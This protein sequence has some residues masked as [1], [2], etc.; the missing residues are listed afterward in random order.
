[1]EAIVYNSGHLFG[2]FSVFNADAIKNT[3]LIKGS[4]PANYGGRLS[5]V[6]DIQMKDGNNKNFG[7]QGGI[8]LISSRLTVEGPIQ[9]EKSSFIISGRRTYAFDLAQP[10]LNNTD[11]RGTNYYFYDLNTKVN[12]QLSPKDRLFFSAYFGKDVL[13]FSSVPRDFNFRMPWGNTTAT[14]RWNHL[15]SDRLFM[16]ASVIYND[17]EFEAQ[18]DQTD[19]TFRL[20]SG[21]RDWNTKVD[22]DFY[23]SAN[24]SIKFG[25]NYT[26]HTFTPN[27]ATATSSDIEF[28]NEAAQKF[29]NESAIYILDD[30]KVNDRLSFN[31]GLRLSMF[32]QVGPFA[33]ADSSRVIGRFE[34]VK[35]YFGLEPRLAANYRL[36]P[37]SSIKAGFARTNQYTH[38]VV[39][40]TSTLP[41]DLWVPSTER[42]K[43]QIGNQYALGYFRNFKDNKYEF[44][45]E[46]YYKDLSNQIDYNEN[47]VPDVN[48]DEEDEFVFGNGESYGLEFFL[49]KR[50]GKLNGWIGYTLSK[51][52]RSFPD[53]DEG[54]TFP[55]KYDRRHDLSIVASYELNDKW[56]FGS[57]FVYGT[58]NTFTI[59]ESFFLIDFQLNANYGVRNGARFDP[60]HRLD[61]SAT[62][63]PKGDQAGVFRSS[64]TFSIYNVYNRQ[65]TF[66]IFYDPSSD[67]VSGDLSLRAVKLSLFPVIPSVT[68]NFKWN[69]S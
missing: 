29:A 64:W 32:A 10:V 58:G 50:T 62:W 2:F 33:N 5:S 21:V 46:A 49:K 3:T 42:V 34:P 63:K 14:L 48:T 16:N 57:T 20:V 59:P 17:Y 54:R 39:N 36:T 66:L 31:A 23:P 27:S 60:Y 38:L 69:Q 9:K 24:H 11:F 43:P 19:F 65:N 13:N 25:L 8:G 51:T 56:T 1:D 68:W 30:F 28:D 45:V 55:A 47:Y 35:R 37:T 22:F 4:M 40:S 41:F 61:L 52:T 44:S 12:F 26:Y 18:G 67:A 53:I 15:F 6:V 7:L